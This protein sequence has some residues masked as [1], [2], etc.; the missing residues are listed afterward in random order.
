MEIFDLNETEVYC[1]MTMDY[2][3]DEKLLIIT[4]AEA[5]DEGDLEWDTVF[6]NFTIHPELYEWIEDIDNNIIQ[7]LNKIDDLENIFTETEDLEPIETMQ[8]Y[9]NNSK[10]KYTFKFDFDRFVF[11]SPYGTIVHLFKSW[12]ND[13]DDIIK[14][15]TDIQY[16]CK[17]VLNYK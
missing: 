7:F 11:S 9:C 16:E 12:D 17:K 6:V 13:K 10:S 2:Y 3:D 1:K 5:S 15:L 4:R 8:I 14:I